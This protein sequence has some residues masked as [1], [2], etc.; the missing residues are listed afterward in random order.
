MHL[1]VCA[2][3][4]PNE[5]AIDGAFTTENVYVDPQEKIMKI[6]ISPIRDSEGDYCQT[7]YLV[8]IIDCI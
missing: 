3:C 5:E 8:D 2:S 7:P 6:D 1:Q 4:Q